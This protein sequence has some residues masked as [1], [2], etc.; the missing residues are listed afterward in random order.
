MKVHVQYFRYVGGISSAQ[1][2]IFETE[3]S[4]VTFQKFVQD[5]NANGLYLDNEKT[6][7]ISPFT[8][9]RIWVV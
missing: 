4:G 7:W 8:I 5:V 2:L 6:D 3:I 1:P 9:Q